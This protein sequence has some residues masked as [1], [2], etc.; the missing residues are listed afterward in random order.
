MSRRG[1]RRSGWMMACA[2]A[3]AVA[4]VLMGGCASPPSVTPLLRVSEAALLA[5]AARLNEDA[6]RDAQWIEQAR[7]ALEQAY[8]ADLAQT[9]E[10]SPAWVREATQVYVAAREAL[11]R[12][13]LALR[14]ERAQRAQNLR[15]AAEA[16]RRATAILQQQDA[17]VTGLA[18]GDAWEL[19]VR[20]GER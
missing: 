13:E 3:V 2:L 6:T 14:Q 4:V 19:V 16:T 17:L 5:E 9:A 18:G 1:R 7:D 10:L 12:H 8:D 20:A 15:A 11:V